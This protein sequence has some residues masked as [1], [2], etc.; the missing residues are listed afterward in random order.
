MKTRVGF[1]R[2]LSRRAVVALCACAALVVL[3]ASPGVV[4]AEA[5]SPPDDAEIVRACPDGSTDAAALKTALSGW[6][7]HVDRLADEIRALPEDKRL[8]RALS[9][10]AGADLGES[11][12]FEALGAALEGCLER[13]GDRVGEEESMS[14]SAAIRP[15]REVLNRH[16]VTIDVGEG[17][18]FIVPEQD[19]VLSRVMPSLP[20][21]A[22]AVAALLLKQ[23][24]RFFED[25]GCLHGVEEMG[26]WAVEWETLLAR[27]LAPDAARAAGDRYRFFMEHLLWSEM[28]NTPTFDRRSGRM[29]K[30]WADGLRAVGRAHPNTRTAAVIAAYL[31]AL[32]PG[33][34]KRSAQA[35]KRAEA[36]IL[37]VI[38]G[39]A[40]KNPQSS[41]R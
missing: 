21:D 26:G 29:G 35:R 2:P 30:E 15:L 38:R 18:Y 33:G 19:A 20:E 7:R 37:R 12:A 9:G 13:L 10:E 31:D 6:T 17:S 4:R 8:E 1:F 27:G 28:D 24:R 25:A 14:S 16:G 23:P 41:G 40:G 22:R 5:P 3:S 34:M 36:A 39:D 11:P 32:K